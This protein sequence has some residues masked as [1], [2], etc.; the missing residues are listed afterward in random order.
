MVMWPYTWLMLN[1]WTVLL[2]VFKKKMEHFFFTSTTSNKKI[3][4]LKTKT[5]CIGLTDP[6]R[7]NKWKNKDKQDG[8]TEH[9]YFYILYQFIICVHR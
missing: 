1:I 4:Y 6:K 9:T 5:T 2:T 3:I 7:K 8:P